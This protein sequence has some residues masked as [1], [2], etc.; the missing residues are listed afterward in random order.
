MNKN[1]LHSLAILTL[2]LSAGRCELL[3]AQSGNIKESG[4]EL[5]DLHHGL[6]LAHPHADSPQA[7]D[8]DPV[9]EGMANTKGYEFRSIDYPGEDLSLVYD[10][11]GKIAV[12]S[13]GADA[14]TLKGSSYVLL[15][16][17]GAEA[18]SAV[19]INTSGKI[20]G[21]YRGSSSAVHGFLYDGSRYT[22]ID[23]P[24]SASTYAWDINDAGVIVGY[25]TDSNGFDH[26]FLNHNG[27]STAIN[28]PGANDTYAYGIN[29]SGD[30]VGFYGDSG[31]GGNGHGFLLSNGVYSSFDAPFANATVAQGIN[32]A[33][34]I[35][36]YYDANF[37]PHGFTYAGGV[38]TTVDVSGAQATELWRIKNSGNVVGVAVDSLGEYHG[39]IGK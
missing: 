27:T 19:G 30:I 10:F 39:I 6:A 21:Y 35:A 9:T 26:G 31:Q 18:S 22:T 20:V 1:L 4:T 16:V 7:P 23:Y 3:T 29:S 34:A 11:N 12:G 36:G 33:G 5:L 8:P 32:D 28:F 37:I 15:N 2:V 25:Y 38:F 13:A 14:F 24:G 17:P